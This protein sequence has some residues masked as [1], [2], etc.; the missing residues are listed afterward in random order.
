MRI[1]KKKKLKVKNLIIL[2][3][4]L[5][6]T[7]VGLNK[8]LNKPKEEIVV[9]ETIPEEK[10]PNEE[11]EEN[12]EEEPE[13]IKGD[14]KVSFFF[15]GDAI[16]HESVY[17]DA[18]N[19]DGTYNFD[20]QLH[21][22]KDIAKEYDLAYYNQETILGGSDLGLS[23]YPTFN[24]PYEFGDYMVEAGFNLVST[25]NNHCLDRGTAG[26]NNS[27]DYWNSKSGVLMQ[28]TN[29]SEEEYNEIKS[30]EVKGIKFAFLSYTYGTNGI[31]PEYPYQVN[32]YPNN[33]EEIIEKIKKAKESNDVVIMAMHWGTEYSMEVNDE[34]QYLAEKFID[35]GA[36]VIVGNHPHVIQPYQEIKGKPVFYAMGNLLSSQL[37]E[38]NLVG[39]IGAMD[40]IKEDDGSIKIENVRCDLIWTAM[41]G[42]Y[43]ALRYNIEVIPFAKLNDSKLADHESIYEKYKAIISSLGFDIQIGGI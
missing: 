33:D 13:V 1:K 16:L 25:A 15:T 31:N 34:Q 22:I 42:V 26:I 12:K 3:C 36:D 38:E 2:L 5:G 27:H 19:D 37:D 4:I 21:H 39:M 14:N 10:K 32:Y 30:I 6:I 41:E 40:F 43:P 23:G 17:V 8:I 7:V 20:K 24:S 35:A 18:Q 9:E 29:T 28:G 11:K